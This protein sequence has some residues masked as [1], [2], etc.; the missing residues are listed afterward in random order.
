MDKRKQLR[1]INDLL[2]QCGDCPKRLIA[3]KP[4]KICGH[5]A[6]YHKIRAEGKKLG[7]DGPRY[8]TRVK[9]DLT[10]PE[11]W[12]LHNDGI[13]D[14][15][16]AFAKDVSPQQVASWKKRHSISSKRVRQTVNLT[17]DEYKR[18]RKQGMTVRQIRNKVGSTQVVFDRWRKEN[19]LVGD[20]EKNV[21]TDEQVLQAL[22]DHKTYWWITKHLHCH[23][24]RAERLAKE[25]GIAR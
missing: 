12:K 5:C 6:L 19:E 13:T 14:E 18:M 20:A 22:M 4:D 10:V 15:A 16:I 8:K 9:I 1:I 3:G 21:A 23:Y 11:Y 7:A 24:Q 2:D 25:H 17:V